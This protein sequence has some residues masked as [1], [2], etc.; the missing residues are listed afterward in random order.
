MAKI[1]ILVETVLSPY[2]LSVRVTDVKYTLQEDTMPKVEK[3]TPTFFKGCIF[4]HRFTF[5]R[6]NILV[7][8]ILRNLNNRSATATMNLGTNS[9][10]NG[11]NSKDSN[12]F[13]S[14]KTAPFMRLSSS[15]PAI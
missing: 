9:A 8:S 5:T 7:Y 12:K 10:P 15:H 1:T 14:N 11:I 4:W 13:S 2:D 3:K 6:H